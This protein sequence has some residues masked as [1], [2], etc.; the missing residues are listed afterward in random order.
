MR[1]VGIGQTRTRSW[2]FRIRLPEVA[3]E[4]EGFGIY[5]YEE[6]EGGSKSI[7]NNWPP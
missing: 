1:L 6:G 7:E 5:E 3:G 2:M 4:D